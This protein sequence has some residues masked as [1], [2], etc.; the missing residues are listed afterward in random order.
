MYG[1][2]YTQYAM[3]LKDGFMVHSVIFNKQNPYTLDTI[4]YNNLGIGRSH[5]CTRL[6]TGEVKWIYD[7]CPVG[8]T[9]QIY[10]SPINGP[11]EPPVLDALIPANM[12]F[13]P[14]DPTVPEAVA[15]SATVQAQRQAQEQAWAEAEASAKAQREAES[16]FLGGSGSITVEPNTLP[17]QDVQSVQ[18]IQPGEPIA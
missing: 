14:T 13:D 1:D 9:V 17:V 4:T 8:T 12:T 10:D 11:F 16:Q 7:N 5:G 18:D 3:R 6:K 2:V 15:Y